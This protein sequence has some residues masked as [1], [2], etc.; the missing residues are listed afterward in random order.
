M[1]FKWFAIM[2]IGIM[3]ATALGS[4]LSSNARAKNYQACVA[5]AKNVKDCDGVR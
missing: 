5:H 4:G 3:L 2:A 1:E